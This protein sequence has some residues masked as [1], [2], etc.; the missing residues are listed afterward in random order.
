MATQEQRAQIEAILNAGLDLTI[1][2][3]REDG[4]PQ[5]TVVSYVSD[6]LAIYFGTW[7][8]S[9]KARNIAREPK[10]SV[11]ITLPY[12]SW[13]EITGVSLGGRARRVT[14][15]AEIERAGALLM[16]KF[17]QVMEFAQTMQAAEMAFIRVDPEVVSILDYAKGFGHTDLARLP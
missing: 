6:G 8:Q 13:G 11:A 12:K 9:Q 14:E 4:Y 17:P 10:V 2:T 1:A 7:A 3:V 15:S 5:A 16:K